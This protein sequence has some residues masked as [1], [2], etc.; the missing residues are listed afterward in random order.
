MMSGLETLM[1]QKEGVQK[2]ELYTGKVEI[3]LSSGRESWFFT[4]YIKKWENGKLSHMPPY[5][6]AARF[7]KS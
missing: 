2:I 1:N 7:Q 3:L 4:I 6:K 5:S